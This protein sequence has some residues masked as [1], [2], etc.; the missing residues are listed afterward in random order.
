MST[1]SFPEI[2]GESVID[3]KD[4]TDIYSALIVDPKAIRENISKKEHTDV[5][6]RIAADIVEIGPRPDRVQAKLQ[7][8]ISVKPEIAQKITTA[9]NEVTGFIKRYN[10]RATQFQAA[11]PD[12]IL[13]CRVKLIKANAV[14]QRFVPDEVLPLVFQFPCSGHVLTNEYKNS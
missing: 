13:K 6:A 2:K 1:V 4:Y 7:S 14:L 10:I 9:I 8:R 12:L 5:L 11:F 3:A